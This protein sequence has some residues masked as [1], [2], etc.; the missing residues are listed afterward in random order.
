MMEYLNVTI[1]LHGVILTVRG[2]YW[3]EEDATFDEPGQP[4]SVEI[5]EISKNGTSLIALFYE[6][7]KLME[8]A[9]ELALAKHKESHFDAMIDALI[10][11]AS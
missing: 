11:R 2:N 7:E 10:E 5:S 4:E 3:P 8:E 9:E 6:C 1:E